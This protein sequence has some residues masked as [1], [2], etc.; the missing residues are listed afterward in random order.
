MI[1]GTISVANID[2]FMKRALP[3]QL[4]HL[5]QK[6]LKV[7]HIRMQDVGLSAVSGTGCCPPSSSYNAM[8]SSAAADPTATRSLKEDIA[9][10][11]NAWATQ[12]VRSTSARSVD[13]YK[14]G[15][16]VNIIKYRFERLLLVS[17][18]HCNAGRLLY[19]VFQ[20]DQWGQWSPSAAGRSQSGA[21]ASIT[22]ATPVLSTDKEDADCYEDDI[23]EAA[24][25]DPD[26]RIVSS[27]PF[28]FEDT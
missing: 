1:C 19:D 15:V 5:E 10:L 22:T 27:H 28:F 6:P 18:Y 23:S 24:E 9:E 21:A 20:V 25:G 16:D 2:I 26:Y 14:A 8:V 11:E 7:T 12:A 3:I 4:R 17:L 13:V